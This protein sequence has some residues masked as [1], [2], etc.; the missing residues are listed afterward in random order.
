MPVEDEDCGFLWNNCT[1]LPNQ[2]TASHISEDHKLDTHH[3]ENLKVHIRKGKY[4]F[5]LTVIS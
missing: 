1:Y 4:V 5:F 2:N 3:Y